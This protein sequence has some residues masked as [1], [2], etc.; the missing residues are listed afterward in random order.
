MISERW[1]DASLSPSPSY[2]G[3]GYL[4]WLPGRTNTK[5]PADTFAANGV[6]G[7]HIYVIPS[8]DLVVVRNGHYD[9]HVG[10]AVADPYLYALYPSFGLVEGAGTIPPDTW[11]DDE[12]LGPIVN[13]VSDP[14]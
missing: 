7:Q 14:K 2:I 9:K 3:Y 13:A 12:F 6:D 10:E 11:S 8:L 4:W 1:I 5:L